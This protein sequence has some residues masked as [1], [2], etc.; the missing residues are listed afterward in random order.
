MSLAT[1]KATHVLSCWSSYHSCA[2]LIS[3]SRFLLDMSRY[4]RA[5]LDMKVSLWPP[6]DAAALLKWLENTTRAQS[7]L[8]PQHGKLRCSYLPVHIFESQNSYMHTHTHHSCVCTTP[9]SIHLYHSKENGVS[10]FR[11]TVKFPLISG[12]CLCSPKPFKWILSPCSVPSTPWFY[13]YF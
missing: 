3:V 8:C 1:Y 9:Q 6:Q 2:L 12:N 13:I 4:L 7:W 5:K 10:V 11:S